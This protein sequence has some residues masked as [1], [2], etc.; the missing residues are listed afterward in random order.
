MQPNITHSDHI[1]YVDESG[2]HSLELVDH[3]YPVASQLI[4][5][6]LRFCM[7]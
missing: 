5:T 2:D 4:P 7:D 1:V 3:D 6:I